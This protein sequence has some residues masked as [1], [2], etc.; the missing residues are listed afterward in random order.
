MSPFLDSPQLRESRLEDIRKSDRSLHSIPI[1][2]SVDLATMQSYRAIPAKYPADR[3][4][5]VNA[6]DYNF[7]GSSFFANDLR[8]HP[9]MRGN[10]AQAERGV[11]VR[12]DMIP[13]LIEVNRTLEPYG[14][15]L[16]LHD[17]YR[18]VAC[19]A[20]IR[21]RVE[22]YWHDQ[23]KS[24]LS[25]KGLREFTRANADKTASQADVKPDPN[26]S[27]TWFTHCT[28]ASLNTTLI[29]RSGAPAEMGGMLVDLTGSQITNYYETNSPR[30]LRDEMA[31]TNRRILFWAMA[32]Q[33]WFN[34]PLLYAA[35]A[36]C[37]T[38]ATQAGIKCA[39]AWG[40]GDV[41]VPTHATI[42]PASP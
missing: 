17:G 18:T 5:L 35:Y 13:S 8:F 23:G 38:Q 36:Y 32:L 12:K 37:S 3:G 2:S 22:G 39:S 10:L 20:E 31:R 4:E 24:F 21:R 16:F 42:G 41:I 14:Y 40:F 29:H 19:Q 11:M 25:E 7:Q 6:L 26:D 1:P 27:T 30:T 15:E 34:Q 28:G 33:G 9:L